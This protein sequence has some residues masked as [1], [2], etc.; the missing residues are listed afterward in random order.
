M[1]KAVHQSSVYN[2]IKGEGR[3]RGERKE[4]PLLRK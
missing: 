1:Y 4:T 2:R 3:D